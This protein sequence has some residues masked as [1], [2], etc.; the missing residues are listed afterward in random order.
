MHVPEAAA[1]SGA[2]GGFGAVQK[3]R[4]LFGESPSS[5]SMKR[6]RVTQGSFV[7][8]RAGNCIYASFLASVTVSMHHF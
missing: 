1:T 4:R 5:S 2:A 8:C 6:P 3:A 7:T